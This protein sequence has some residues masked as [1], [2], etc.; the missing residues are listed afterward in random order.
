MHASKQVL[1]LPRNDAKCQKGF[2]Q[3][4]TEGKM[5]L[6]FDET[7]DTNVKTGK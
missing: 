5:E 4:V 3:V 7:R 1:I 6:E 2:K